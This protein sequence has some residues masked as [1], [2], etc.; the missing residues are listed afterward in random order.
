MILGEVGTHPHALS[1][2]AF[3][4]LFTKNKPVI[5]N[6]HGF[7]KDVSSLLFCRS[8]HVGRSRFDI[9]GGSRTQLPYCSALSLISFVP[10]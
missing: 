1:A 9:L 8:A 10:P 3:D 6:F 4:G 2:D 7:P 5:F